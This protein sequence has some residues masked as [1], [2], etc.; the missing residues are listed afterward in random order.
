MGA[1]RGQIW[2]TVGCSWAPSAAPW[3][4]APSA[5][6]RLRISSPPQLPRPFWSQ[7]RTGSV[8]STAG[9]A[10]R[11]PSAGE[12]SFG[13]GAAAPGGQLG[14]GSFPAE[15][16]VLRAQGSGGSTSPRE[17]GNGLQPRVPPRCGPGEVPGGFGEGSAQPMPSCTAARGGLASHLQPQRAARARRRACT[18]VQAPTGTHTRAHAPA[19]AFDFPLSAASRRASPPRYVCSS[20]RGRSAPAGSPFP[21]SGMPAIPPQPVSR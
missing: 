3:A 2:G 16:P 12:E 11:V 19:G 21:S 9:I 10:L 5:S 17:L 14:R 4:P 18:H 1:P 13:R 8:Q 6:P 15:G 20:S 7:E